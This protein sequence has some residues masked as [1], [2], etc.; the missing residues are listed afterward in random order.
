LNLIENV[1]INKQNEIHQIL[2]IRKSDIEQN[3]YVDVKHYSFILCDAI[4]KQ[5]SNILTFQLNKTTK[6]SVQFE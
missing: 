2:I 1:T 4:K 3:K 6:Y 5:I